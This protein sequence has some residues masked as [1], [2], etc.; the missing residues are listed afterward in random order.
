M[1]FFHLY[2]PNNNTHTHIHKKIKKREKVKWITCQNLLWA[3]HTVSLNC[4]ELLQMSAKSAFPLNLGAPLW[5]ITWSVCL[6]FFVSINNSCRNVYQQETQKRKSA[7]KTLNGLNPP[8]IR[9]T[10]SSEWQTILRQAPLSS[11]PPK[12]IVVCRAAT[13]H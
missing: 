9:K 7:C 12:K 2:L 6:E 11:P 8:R 4:S 3:D 13:C 1:Y 5:K 10:N